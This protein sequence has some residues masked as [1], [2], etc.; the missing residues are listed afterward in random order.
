M[1]ERLDPYYVA[2][3]NESL[4]REESM[5]LQALEQIISESRIQ[6]PQFTEALRIND[7][8]AVI[9]EHKRRSPSEGD[10]RPDSEVAWRVEQ[11]RQGGAIALSILTQQKHFNGSLE[12]LSEARDAQ[13]GHGL[14]LPILRKDFIRTPYQLYEAKAFGADAV[15]LIL[16]GLSDPQFRDL[17][18]EATDIGLDCLVEVHSRKDL[19]RALQ[20]KPA[21]IGI[22]NRDLSNME[23]DRTITHEL[24]EEVPDYSTVVAESGY[25]VEE[26]ADMAELRSLGVD[27]VLIGTTLV[28]DDDPAIS[29]RRWL[30]PT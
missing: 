11:Y 7:G 27:A 3:Q 10:I 22:N 14:A 26:P 21:L 28:R 19:H 23:V 16:A 25:K 6:E 24:M 9:A 15:L 30:S 29:L 20:V 5:P 1:S 2:A 13:A 4:V 12:D 8:V 18:E 17:H